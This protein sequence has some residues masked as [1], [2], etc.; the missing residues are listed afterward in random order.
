[1]PGN[2][3]EGIV[4]D[5]NTVSFTFDIELSGQ[6]VTLEFDLKLDGESFD[7]TVSVGAFGTY[8]LKG[9]RTSKPN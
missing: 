4:I 8:P 1:M 7:G 2:E 5:G 6:M 3:L 9:S